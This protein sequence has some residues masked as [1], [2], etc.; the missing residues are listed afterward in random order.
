MKTKFGGIAR[1]TNGDLGQSENVRF[2]RQAFAPAETLKID[3]N[4][5]KIERLTPAP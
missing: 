1:V 4:I 5:P 2:G 3:Y